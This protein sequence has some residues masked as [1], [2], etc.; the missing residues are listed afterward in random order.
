[1]KDHFLSL[2]LPYFDC[3]VQR[4]TQY[5]WMII[6]IVDMDNSGHLQFVSIVYGDPLFGFH[7]NESDVGKRSILIFVSKVYIF[8]M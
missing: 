6:V 7:V 3:A 8:F 5:E 2:N 4:G 1:M